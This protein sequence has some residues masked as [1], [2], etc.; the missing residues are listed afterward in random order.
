LV[1]FLGVVLNAGAQAVADEI[2]PGGTAGKAGLAEGDLLLRAA[3][4]PGAEGSAQGPWV[5]IS[6]PFS[7]ERFESVRAGWGVVVVEGSRNGEPARWQMGPGKSGLRLRPLLTGPDLAALKSARSGGAPS[8]PALEALAASLEKSGNPSGACWLWM[9]SA[10]VWGGQ[11]R[12]PEAM[13]A[14]DHAAS[15][16]P[17]A[18]PEGPTAVL[19]ERG[20]LLRKKGDLAGAGEA[21]GRAAAQ[22]ASSF[23]EKD[24]WRAECLYRQGAAA[25]VRRDLEAAE[26]PHQEAL[27]IRRS[28]APGSPDEAESLNSL[29]GIAF[30]RADLD[31]AAAL[32]AQALAL[33][34][35]ADP[36]GVGSSKVL[37]NLG[38]VHRNLG[39]LPEAEIY[40]RRAL[41]IQRRLDPGSLALANSLNNLGLITH[42]KGDLAQAEAFHREALTIREKNDPQG[43]AVAGSLNNLA[44]VA[45]SRGDAVQAEAWYRRAVALME[46]R[47][48]G[49]LDLASCLSNL[50]AV[51]G[52]QGKSPEA[53]EIHL[54]ALTIEESFAPE[55]AGAAGSHYN[56]GVEALRTGN[57]KEAATQFGTA[58]SLFRKAAPGG[59]GLS[60]AL[61]QLGRLDLDRK[62]AKQARPLLAEALAIRS[63]LAPGS[64]AEAEV[65]AALSRA[66]D[67]ERRPEEG[68][69]WSLKALDALESQMGRLGGSHEV[70]AEYRSGALPFYEEAMDRLLDA[71][72]GEEAF[73][74]F[75]RAR[76]RVFLEMLG[77][78]DLTVSAHLQPELEKE[79]RR[80]DRSY[81]KTMEALAEL[82]ARSEAASL[83]SLNVQL[84]EIRSERAAL[85]QRVRA[86]SPA[87]GAL[88]Y[89]E[90]L[91][92]AGVR[93]RLDPGTVLV[94]FSV[95]AQR[96]RVFALDARGGFKSV[97]VPLGR[98]DLAGKVEFFRV[99]ILEAKS[100]GRGTSLI[101]ARGGELYDVLLSPVVALL[102]QAR[103]LV[104]VPDG[105]LNA[106][107]F[108]AL[109][110]NG[111]AE[112]SFLSA[113]KAYSVAPS[114]TVYAAMR[115]DAP[116]NGR[117]VEAAAFAWTGQGESAD[118][119]AALAASLKEA[120]AVR[121]LVKETR[122][123]QGDEATEAN[124]RLAARRA[125][126]LHF[127]C[128]ATL[129]GRIPLNSC[130]L[131]MGKSDGVPAEDGE[132]RAWEIIEEVRTPASLV[133]LS[134]CETGLG[135]EVAGE[136][137]MGLVRAFHV[138]GASS[139]VASLWRVEDAATAALMKAFYGNLAEG[140]PPAEALRLAQAD[141]RSGAAKGRPLP[142][143]YWAAFQVYGRGE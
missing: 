89:P 90:P 98:E 117:A 135:R 143:Y 30:A 16:A 55:G 93:T 66:A 105:P 138:S 31:G 52:A 13:S 123:Y 64:F 48:P 43:P 33:F 2:A 127:A 84:A 112:G 15:L 26:R 51:L 58:A 22:C 140:R 121:K 134:A 111:E 9:Q 75:E 101:F 11:K 57:K 53:R 46:K 29:G 1:L 34:E 109:R 70:R 12:W 82:D 14:L 20:N 27:A 32:Y 88:A 19:L 23:A 142:P 99:A 108:G 69:S 132:L 17:A 115:R 40:V 137:L 6:S 45:E 41:E 35:T 18:S 61:Y 73:G 116:Q 128:H 133:V 87:L 63:R 25:W 118:A 8:G 68:I 103:R 56:L 136:G 60:G 42:E 67:L 4:T 79:R 114:A 39:D 81:G 47:A 65:L 92:A 110:L 50:G 139:V 130:L 106:L 83:K 86:A 85:A 44:G 120:E 97:V 113:R 3:L 5:E 71:E 49:S 74:V 107:P 94:A 7:W 38:S 125:Q 102:G 104:I 76:A 119:P 131:L 122:V 59:L 62:Q 78:R 21:Y 24:L 91:D 141:L 129:D 72:K 80:L 36:G 10:S 124:A 37:S 77:E 96:T 126:V 95:G 100:P 54:K 28:L